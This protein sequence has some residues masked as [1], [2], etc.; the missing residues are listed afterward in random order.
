MR[1]SEEVLL[2]R[3]EMQRV[4]EFLNWHEDWWKN[5]SSRRTGL[6]VPIM[7]GVVAYAHKQAR[8]RR[9]LHDKF[10]H[11]WRQSAELCA[12]GIGADSEILS[13]DVA[14]N[15]TLASESE[16]DEVPPPVSVADVPDPDPES[17]SA[18][19]LP[20]RVHLLDDAPA[21]TAY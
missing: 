7:E 6:Q 15:Y 11:A 16:I 13:S 10:N 4:L 19:T 14:V 18:D 2:L 9:S 5:Q 1:F 20:R 3:A 12:L 8:Y 17:V 21:P